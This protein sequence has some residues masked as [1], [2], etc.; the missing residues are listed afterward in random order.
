MSLDKLD[1]NCAHVLFLEWQLQDACLQCVGPFYFAWCMVE[2]AMMAADTEGPVAVIVSTGRWLHLVGRCLLQLGQL[3]VHG[4]RNTAAGVESASC[5]VDGVDIECTCTRRGTS[6]RNRRRARPAGCCKSCA[7]LQ[8]DLAFVAQTA[9]VATAMC[10]VGIMRVCVQAGATG[11]TCQETAAAEG[12]CTHT[13]V[14]S[15]K[16][17]SALVLQSARPPLGGEGAA[18][19]QAFEMGQEQLQVLVAA[20]QLHPAGQPGLRAFVAT[21]DW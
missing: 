21:K 10:C 18:L 9:A 15:H 8:D 17:A 20:A 12:Q 5:V 11:C 1:Q 4:I 6:S 14:C 16:P 7:V 2:N 3:V 13:F 19:D